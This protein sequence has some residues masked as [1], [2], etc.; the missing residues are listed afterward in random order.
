MWE[1][2]IRLW[3]GIIITLFV[4][5]HLVNHALGLISLDAMEGMRK[6]MRVIWSGAPGGPILMLSFLAHFLLSLHALFK[7]STF[8]MP[9]WE[10]VQ[11]G[12]GIIIFPLIL[13]HVAGTE[14]ASDML[15]FDPTYEYVIAALWVTPLCL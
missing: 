6:G 2:R 7:R 5:P 8:R 3:S 11:I 10:A 14:I 12:L 15:K 13:T 1:R 9:V 4:V